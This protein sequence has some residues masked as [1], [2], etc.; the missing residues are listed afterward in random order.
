MMVLLIFGLFLPNEVSHSWLTMS[1]MVR[2]S[3]SVGSHVWRGGSLTDYPRIIL[4]TILLLASF[5][6]LDDPMRNILALIGSIFGGILIFCNLGSRAFKKL[7]IGFI[8]SNNIFSPILVFFASLSTGI[9]FPF[10]GLRSVHGGTDIQDGATDVEKITSNANGKRARQNITCAA[11]I[12][13]VI[14]LFSGVT[15]I[16]ESL[17]FNF[18][19]NRA[20]VNLVIGIWWFLSTLGSMSLCHRLDSSQSKKIEPFLR[21]EET[22]PVGWI[23][24][25]VPNI[26]IDPN[27]ARGRMIFPRLRYGSDV[28]SA[29]VLTAIAM[30]MIWIGLRE[31]QGDEVDSF[32]D[33]I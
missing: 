24:P 1:I 23:M 28:I 21:R 20:Y 3:N 16:Q 14:F 17:G 7:E 22:S 6:S 8:D 33:W 4:L 11:T 30:C 19:K 29:L 15:S 9:V 25:S 2:G 18:V 31:L 12:V 13:A 5:A 10:I 27:L 32:W 26:V